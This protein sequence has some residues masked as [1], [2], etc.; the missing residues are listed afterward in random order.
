MA[1]E[2]SLGSLFGKAKKW[3]KQELKNMSNVTADPR[4]ARQAEREQDRLA[5]EIENDAERMRDEA[6]FDAVV[7]QGMKDY[8]ADKIARQDAE[9]A[10]RAARD[11]ADR[12]ARAGASSVEL[13]GHVTGDAAL[14]AVST[15]SYD[16]SDSIH[17]HVEAIDPVP[18]KGGTFV[19]FTFAIPGHGDGTYELVVSDDFDGSWYELYDADA[20]KG[21]YFDPSYG[22]GTIVVADGVADVLLTFGNSSSELIQLRGRVTL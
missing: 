3:A 14:L 1:K 8:Q 20:A 18:M 5:R 22:P 21:W 10:E 17:V 9:R 6:I 13:T 11:R 16:G 7:T 12:E 19:G 2:D 4:E 15:T